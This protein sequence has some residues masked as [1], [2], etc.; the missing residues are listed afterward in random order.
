M[1]VGEVRADE[2]KAWL[3]RCLDQCDVVLAHHPARPVA[4][5]DPGLGASRRTG[6]R[7]SDAPQRSRKGDSVGDP[8]LEAPGELT[9]RAQ[10]GADPLGA[11]DELGLWKLA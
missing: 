2:Q 11:I 9:K 4:D 10:P 8:V 7:A 3:P 5:R 1:G 6:E